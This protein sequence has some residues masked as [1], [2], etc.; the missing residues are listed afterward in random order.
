M[1][2]VYVTAPGGMTF[3]LIFD[4]AADAAPQSFRDGIE[5]G[6]L[7]LSQEIKDQITVNLKIDY[8]RHGR[9]SERGA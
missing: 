6:A 3:H 9:R 7:L 1:S 8:K 4:A 5:A 2:E